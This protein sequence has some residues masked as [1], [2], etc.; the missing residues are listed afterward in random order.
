MDQND[1]I[2]LLMIGIGLLTLALLIT[3]LVCSI[4]SCQR[5]KK[6]QETETGVD[7]LASPVPGSGEDI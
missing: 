1:L 3:I 2:L 5:D 4:K 7:K 6:Q